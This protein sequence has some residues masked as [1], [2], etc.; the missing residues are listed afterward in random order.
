MF[1]EFLIEPFEEGE[2]LMGCISWAIFLLLFTAGILLANLVGDE[3]STVWDLV[4]HG[5]VFCDD[6]TVLR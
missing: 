3:I 6:K 5:R 4:E 1:S 2:W